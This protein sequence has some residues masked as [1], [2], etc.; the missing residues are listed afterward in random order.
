MGV[1]VG[2]EWVFTPAWNGCSRLRGLC[3]QRTPKARPRRGKGWFA[4]YRDVIILDADN[5]RAAV[6]NLTTYDLSNEANRDAL[7][8]LLLDARR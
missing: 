5:R 2:V 8:Q 6:Y 7:K 1:H 3:T 4:A